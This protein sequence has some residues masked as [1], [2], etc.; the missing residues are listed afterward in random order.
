[1]TNPS[2]TGCV[3]QVV[4]ELDTGGVEQ[5]VVDVSAAIIAAGGRSIVATKGGRLET[6]LTRQGATVVH[7]PVHSKH[8]LVQ[9]KNY[10]ALRRLIRTEG[11]DIV[12]VRSR[13]PALA[14]IRAAKASGVRSVATYHGIYNAKSA[15]KRWYNSLMTRADMT[16]ANSDYTRAHILATYP[17]VPPER[18]ISI[19]RGIDMKR[20]DPEGFDVRKIMTLEEDWGLTAG[21]GRIRFLLAGRLTRWKGQ[22][23]IVEAANLLRLQDIDTFAVV[24]AGDDQGRGDYTQGLRDR[25]ASYGLSE[26]IRLVGHVSDMPSA[27]TACHFALAPSLDPEAFGRTAV[28]PQAMQRP[29]L[30]AAHGATVETVLPGETGWLVKPGDAQA[31]ADAMKA[32]IQMP[33]AD[34]FEMGRRARAHVRD[35]YSLPLMC[36]RTLDVYRALLILNTR[37][38]RL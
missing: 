1:M 18:V 12:H 13:A 8:P 19:P 24:M 29:P 17:K 4:P 5:T 25:I 23:L 2:F 33:E 31:W 28:E 6:Q 16:I 38:Y 27:Y 15:I 3:L 32:A 7:I 35:Q 36:E 21:D 14:A 11:I 22:E 20:F 26:Q 30:A 10:H 9:L 37:P 34:R